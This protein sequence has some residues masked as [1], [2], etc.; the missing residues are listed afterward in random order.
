MDKCLPSIQDEKAHLH[1]SM[2][3][4]AE[5]ALCYKMQ[6][7]N[8]LAVEKFLALMLSCCACDSYAD[9]MIVRRP[10]PNKAALLAGSETVCASL[11][12]EDWR[13]AIS[14][15]A[16]IGNRR[17]DDGER[18]QRWSS[19]EQ[20][21]VSLSGDDV[22]TRIRQLSREYRTRHGFIFL[23]CATGKS[24]EDIYE[25]LKCRIDNDTELE[26]NNAIREHIQITSIR[27]LKS[28][29]EL[30]AN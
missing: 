1:L 21:K 13:K 10:F 5:P 14:A 28:I 3:V 23:I 11:S 19:Q 7:L 6:K 8:D 9:G 18:N 25:S 17:D 12:R 22:V 4:F 26:L 16:E 30:L 20:S 15:H 24:G 27:L 2:L 29:D